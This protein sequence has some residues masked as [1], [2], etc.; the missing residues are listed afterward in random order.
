MSERTSEEGI[1]TDDACSVTLL[2]SGNRRRI[3]STLFLLRF[4]RAL[5][6]SEWPSFSTG[7]ECGIPRVSSWCHVFSGFV[8][9]YDEAARLR[10][11]QRPVA[12]IEM[13]VYTVFV[14]LKISSSV[15][16]SLQQPTSSFPSIHERLPR[17]TPKKTA[18]PA[19]PLLVQNGP[20]RCL[21]FFVCASL[22]VRLNALPPLRPCSSLSPFSR[23]SSCFR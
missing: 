4:S 1:R 17:G 22:L 9:C 23:R 16:A 14:F 8:Q 11:C 3:V 12:A 20:G 7:P 2:Q 18:H 15:N 5:S 13:A 21:S 19:H 6:L 10:A